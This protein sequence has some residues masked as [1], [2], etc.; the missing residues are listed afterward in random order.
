[1]LRLPFEI[2]L[3]FVVSVVADAARPVICPEEMLLFVSVF[4]LDGVTTFPAAMLG[5]HS[6]MTLPVPSVKQGR[7]PDVD[8][9]G[10]VTALG[11]EP[12]LTAAHVPFWQVYSVP[13][14]T[15]C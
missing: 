3:A 2:L 15:S 4:V 6:P 12:P 9:E 5:E 11:V 10:L 1:V 14:G 8:V 13:A 7:S